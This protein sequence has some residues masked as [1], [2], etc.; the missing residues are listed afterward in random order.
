MNKNKTT[1][2]VLHVLKSLFARHDIPET[3]RSNNGQP[4]GSE[5]YVAFAREWGCN[6][7]ISHP[8]FP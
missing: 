7:S 6:I 1:S 3:L 4:F 2:E 5:A 8:A